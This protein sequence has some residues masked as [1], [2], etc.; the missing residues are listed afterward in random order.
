MSET[1]RQWLF[2]KRP[3]GPPD[4]SC[5]S[6]VERPLTPLAEGHIR[7]RLH[8]LS[9]DPYMRG[10]MDD[11]RSYAPPQALNEVMQ[12]GGVGEI[13]ETRNPKFKVGDKLFGGF[14]WQTFADSDGRGVRRVDDS[15]IKLS[16]YLGPVGMPG[17]TAWFG[18]NK[19]IEPRAGETIVVSAASGAVGSVVG[20][21][22][23]AKGC[24]VVG[25]AGGPAKCRLV[26]EGYGFDACI[27]Y[28]SPDFAE[29]L[30]AATPD[31]I[32]GV[33]ENVGG[34]VLDSSLARMNAFGRIAVC[35]LISGYNGE[36]MLINNFRSI[37]VNRLKVQGFI[38]SEQPAIWGEA[39][40]E[41]AAGVAS[42]AIRYHETVAEGIEATPE[43]LFGLLSGRNLGK[44]VVKLI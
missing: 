28:R 16:A 27:D 31:R 36:P 13:V 23:K 2:V 20:Q 18:L 21:L 42:S 9:V 1:N 32:D 26:T 12:G 7:V 4:A 24:R 6:L 35:G 40:G 43:A 5:F 34:K 44:Q 10:R 30:R 11:V 25:I 29:M 41:L 8:Y 38:I 33:F 37:L 15:V 14:G 17:V 3:A 19:I 39:L 22:A